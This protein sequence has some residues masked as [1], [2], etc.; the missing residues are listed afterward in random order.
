MDIDA[1]VLE[2]ELP[3]SEEFKLT[4]SAD[5]F[6]DFIQNEN[7]ALVTSDIVMK[8]RLPKYMTD[9]KYCYFIHPSST[10]SIIAFLTVSD[11]YEVTN[12]K[13]M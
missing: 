4:V 5:S 9:F 2:D 6:T 7:S 8:L 12:E 1:K 3:F 11:Y 13:K 10:F